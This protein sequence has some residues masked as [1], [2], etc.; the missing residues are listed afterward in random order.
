MK[1]IA[2]A[3][4]TVFA[5]VTLA[6]CCCYKTKKYPYPQYDLSPAKVCGAGPCAPAP[7]K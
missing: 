7:C 1:A 3:V 4:V 6:G 5:A 2:I